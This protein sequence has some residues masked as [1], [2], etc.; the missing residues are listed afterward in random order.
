MV[1]IRQYYIEIQDHIRVS[2]MPKLIKKNYSLSN[3]VYRFIHK[4][5]VSGDL[6]PGRKITEA[7]ISNSM[8]I[9][10]AP[11]REALKQLAEDSLVVLIPRTGCV[12]ADIN[13]DEV[14]EI[15][16]IRKRLECLA[17]EY[18]WE[19]FS[20]PEVEDLRSQFKRCANL[21]QA[22]ILE[23]EIQLDSQLHRLIIKTSGSKILDTLLGKLQARIGI[24][25]IREA[26]N[27]NRAINAL[28]EHLGLLD[29]IIKGNKK[30]A[31]RW[32]A[33]HISNSKE[34]LLVIMVK[35]E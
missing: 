15:C 9:S 19:K 22:D 31:L 35:S 20:I 29:A 16:E 33:E 8:G 11:V 3:K 1:D 7:E 23:R 13:Y 27:T 21:S 14:E 5:I 12:I 10:R 25:R 24:F 6:E 32:L 2:I 30:E 4:Q 34:A 17:L 18:A 26:V 28:K